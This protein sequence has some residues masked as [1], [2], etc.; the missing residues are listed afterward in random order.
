MILI[1]PTSFNERLGDLMPLSPYI[2]NKVYINATIGVATR[3]KID[4]I[5][6]PAKP[7]S[8]DSPKSF[9]PGESA[10]KKKVGVIKKLITRKT[11]NIDIFN[12]LPFFC[13]LIGGVFNF[14]TWFGSNCLGASADTGIGG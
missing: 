3:P 13:W 14:C 4:V 1:K 12:F 10:A 9:A 6:A 5:K 8:P 2:A 7:S 11:I